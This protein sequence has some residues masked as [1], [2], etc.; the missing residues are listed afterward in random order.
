MVPELEEL[1]EKGYFTKDEIKEIVRRRENFEYSLKRRTPA[2]ADFIRHVCCSQN[3]STHPGTCYII[4][5]SAAQCQLELCLW[6]SPFLWM[7]SMC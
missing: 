3:I 1:E 5:F 4:L 7:S 6:H 2:K